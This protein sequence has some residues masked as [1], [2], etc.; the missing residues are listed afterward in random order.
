M[1]QGLL[2]LV[3]HLAEGVFGI[4]DCFIDDFQRF[5]HSLMSFVQVQPGQ[6]IAAR[7]E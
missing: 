7:R 1:P 6:K 3:L 4:V 5:G 2:R